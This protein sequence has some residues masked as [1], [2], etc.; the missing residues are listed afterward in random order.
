MN[1]KMNDDGKDRQ[2]RLEHHLLNDFQHSLPLSTTPFADMAEVLGVTEDEVLNTLRK[3]KED[4]TISRV[5]AVFRAN[6]VGASTLAAMAVRP[7]EIE[8]IAEIVNR[9][10]AV[11][12]NYQRE[13]QY[14]LWFVL[15]AENERVLATVIE[16][17]EQQ[18]GYTVMSLPMLEDYYINLGFDIK[19]T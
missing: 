6:G 10:D 1:T 7:D 19:W 5:G 9:F 17:I 4:G 3:K 11:N 12:H 8:E 14:N 2:T 15:T 16:N 13:H 18:C